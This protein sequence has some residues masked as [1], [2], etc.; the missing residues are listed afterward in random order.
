[1]QSG[2]LF[3]LCSTDNDVLVNESA[4]G[5]RQLRE[6]E[7]YSTMLMNVMNGVCSSV[8]FTI[9]LAKTGSDVGGVWFKLWKADC[10]RTQ[11]FQL[12]VHVASGLEI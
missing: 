9:S 3:L 12:P 11:I 10:C 8:C 7:K 4:S 5:L 1:M 2:L 6:R